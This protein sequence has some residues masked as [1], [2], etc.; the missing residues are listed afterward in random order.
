MPLRS[1]SP[2]PLQDRNA[3]PR[4]PEWQSSAAACDR[5]WRIGDGAI[6]GV[7]NLHVI[8]DETRLPIPGAALSVGGVDGITMATAWSSPTVGAQTVIAK[9]TG[10][11]DAKVSAIATT[12]LDVQDFGLD[13]DRDKR[14]RIAAQPRTR[15]AGAP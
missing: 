7:A 11:L 13:A 10:A 8:D 4:Q 9:A 3:P 1:R 5:R 6:D 2:S 15:A 12:G 14:D